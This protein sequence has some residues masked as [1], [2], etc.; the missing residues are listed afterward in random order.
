[1]SFLVFQLRAPMASFGS[2]LTELRL[3]DRRPRRSVVTGLLAAAL[4]IERQES[5]RFSQLATQVRMAVCVLNE[6]REFQDFHTIQA[7]VFSAAGSRAEQVRKIAAASSYKG[8]MVTRRE[9][10]QDGHWL[11]A[12]YADTALLETWRAALE[13]P[14]FTLYLGRKSCALSAFCAPLV[15]EVGTAEAALQQWSAYVTSVVLP[16]EV[17]LHWDQGVPTAAP[18]EWTCVRNDVRAH[19]LRNHFSPRTEHSGPAKLAR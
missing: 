10:L 17:E 2:S 7:P 18:S 14:L 19:L 6:P 16:P 12:L 11:V 13:Q 3:S 9:Y 5:E 8:T 4:G 15:V 1:M